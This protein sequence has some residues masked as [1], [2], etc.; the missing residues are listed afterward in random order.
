VDAALTGTA[1]G[2]HGVQQRSCDGASLP[3]SLPD[4]ATPTGAA[5]VESDGST[6][7]PTVVDADTASGYQAVPSDGAVLVGD[8]GACVSNL[9]EPLAAAPPNTALAVSFLD[10]L[11]N[12]QILV[13]PQIVDTVQGALDQAVALVDAANEQLRTYL[14]AVAAQV[15]ALGGALGTNGLPGSLPGGSG[16]TADLPSVPSG[17]G[18]PTLPSIPPPV[19]DPVGGVGGTVDGVVDDVTGTVGGVVCGLLGCH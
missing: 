13:V 7:E 18:T 4:G 1:S 2:R 12:L 8:G 16:G 11:G 17:G 6:T 14:D 19:T 10:Q 15:A 9:I 3:L 5:L